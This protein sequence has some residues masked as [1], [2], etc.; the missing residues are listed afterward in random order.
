MNIIASDIPGTFPLLSLVTF[1]QSAILEPA[2]TRKAIADV[3]FSLSE[4]I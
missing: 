4:T 1:I 3:L 2:I